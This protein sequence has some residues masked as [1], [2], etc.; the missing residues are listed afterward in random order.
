MQVVL[1]ILFSIILIFLLK[2]RLN[3]IK[4]NNQV[5]IFDGLF[6][7]GM[8][9]TFLPVAYSFIVGEISILNT[10]IFDPYKD[11]DLLLYVLVSNLIFALVATFNT[12]KVSSNEVDNVTL[13]EKQF[14]IG[15]LLFY[16]FSLIVIFL[17]SGKLEGGSHWYRANAEVYARGPIYVLLGQFHNVG[18]VFIPGMCLFFQLKYLKGGKIFKPHFY[19][20]GLLIVMELIMSG[21]RIV[22][23]FFVF[24]IVIPFFLYGY[25]KKMILLGLLCFPLIIVAKFWPM[26][27]GLLWAEEVS[28]NRFSEVI[29]LAYENE[30]NSTDSADPFLVLTE[31]SNIAALKYV[32]DNYPSRNSYT[33]GDTMILKSIGALVPKSIWKDKP[34]GIGHEVGDSVVSGVSLYLNV[35][36][37]GDAWANFGWFGI[38]YILFALF[39]FQNA[40]MKFFPAKINFISSLA[41]M[42][43][44]AAWRFEFSF[45]FISLYTFLMFLLIFK[46]RIFRYLYNIISKFIF[47]N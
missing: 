13:F 26:V 3:N 1:L 5:T 25:Y 17:S 19:I 21:N 38:L 33:F 12:L 44:I 10:L 7:G 15:V 2:K 27:R 11:A 37:L 8:F 28:F 47:K 35:T 32:T 36:I 18:R 6:F 43:S 23:L 22:I 4:K 39:L 14:F 20:A 9:F 31:G 16:V 34:D 45:Y 30:Q 46:F 24:S 41:F 40:I 29:Q 42:A